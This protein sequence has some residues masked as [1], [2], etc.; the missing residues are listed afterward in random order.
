MS[1][2]TPEEIHT[3]FSTAFNAGDLN[4]LMALYEPDATLIPQPGEIT[5]GRDAIRQTLQQFLALKGTMQLRS[6]YVVN[7][8]GVALLSSQWTLTGIG[9]DGK[10]LEMGGKG[11]EVAR[12]QPGGD[13]LLAVDHP[14]GAD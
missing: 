8:P 6:L 13:W 11:V 10:P 1:A 5:R 14:F 2:N 7:G 3:L 9:P 4:A 12:Q